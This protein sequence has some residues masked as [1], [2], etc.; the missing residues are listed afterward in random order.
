M[1]KSAVFF[2]LEDLAKGEI[3]STV[4]GPKVDMGNPQQVNQAKQTA[5]T[6]ATKIRTNSPT[7]GFKSMKSKEK[8]CD[9]SVSALADL[10]KK[11]EDFDMAAFDRDNPVFDRDERSVPLKAYDQKIS[12]PPKAKKLNADAQARK[13]KSART[14]KAFTMLPPGRARGS[15]SPTPT[16]GR[17]GKKQ[18]ADEQANKMKSASVKKKY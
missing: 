1:S 9:K 11:S 17:K 8:D 7:A 2:K 4:A 5:R 14:K 13:M 18:S 3:V 16:I 10:I 6:R 15:E 12:A